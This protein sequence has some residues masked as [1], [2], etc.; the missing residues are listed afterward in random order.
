MADKKKCAH[1]SCTCQTEHKYCSAYCEQ[2]EKTAEISCQ[3]GHPDCK[4]ELT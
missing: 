4:A 1:P 3:C 2:H